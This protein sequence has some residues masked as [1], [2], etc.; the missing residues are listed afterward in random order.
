MWLLELEK[1]KR[2]VEALPVVK[3]D[4]YFSYGDRAND[5]KAWANLWCCWAPA[6]RTFKP[7]AVAC[8]EKERPTHLEALRALGAK[9]RNEHMCAGHVH[10][11]RA[12][13]RRAELE[14]DAA[15]GCDVAASGTVFDRMR[16]AQAV[17][18]RMKAIA[19]ADETAADLARATERAATLYYVVATHTT[20]LNLSYTAPPPAPAPAILR[21]ARAGGCALKVT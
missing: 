12:V 14:R 9:I 10:A 21:W 18:Q 3:G 16:L 2:L 8:H 20:R 5:N 11:E 15:L 1:E 6:Q 7:V 4:I 13:Q 17:Q 19:D